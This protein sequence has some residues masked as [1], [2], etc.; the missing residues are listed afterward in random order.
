M[1]V[2]NKTAYATIG[3]DVQLSENDRLAL[4]IELDK[5]TNWLE[6]VDVPETSTELY[7]AINKIAAFISKFAIRPS[8]TNVFT[9][10]PEEFKEAVEAI[11]S[12]TA[13]EPVPEDDV[14][15]VFRG[16]NK[17]KEET[18]KELVKAGYQTKQNKTTL[19]PASTDD[20]VTV[21]ITSAKTISMVNLAKIIRSATD[22]SI[23]YISK[24]I[25]SAR[26]SSIPNIS[27][28]CTRDNKRDVIYR[29][30]H[31]GYAIVQNTAES[32]QLE[33]YMVSHK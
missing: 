3:C 18:I 24:F 4:G 29:L 2:T 30:E 9:D 15:T 14:I 1:K 11:G 22:A 12:T 32:L 7:K 19:E 27:F 8:E 21:D 17:S 5:V 33:N 31:L 16:I 6:T 28:K 25:N 20:V 13:V 23:A 10:S 26:E